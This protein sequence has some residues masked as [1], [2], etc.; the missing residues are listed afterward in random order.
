M[1]NKI[2]SSY[3]NEMNNLRNPGNDIN[4]NNPNNINI[5]N[6]NESNNIE[7]NINHRIREV[8]IKYSGCTPYF[9]FGNTIFF[10]F[11]NSLKDLNISDKY[12]ENTVD[13]SQMPDPPFA[14]GNKCKFF[15]LFFIR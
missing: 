3:S 12:S 11:P 1:N 10:Y 15:Y 6:N 14:I 8:S 5:D 7:A 9:E 13:L 2:I 4:A